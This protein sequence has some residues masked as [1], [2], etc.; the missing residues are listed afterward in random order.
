MIH[1]NEFSKEFPDLEY[2]KSFVNFFSENYDLLKENGATDF[3]IFIEIYYV[4]QC[5]FEIFNRDLLVELAKY[6]VNLPISV[7]H[8]QDVD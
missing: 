7:Y 8:I 4:D 1:E 5:N 2:E 3:S 6:R